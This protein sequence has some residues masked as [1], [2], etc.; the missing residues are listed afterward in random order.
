MALKYIPIVETK[1]KERWGFTVEWMSG[2]ADHYEPISY[3]FDT[4]EKFLEQLKFFRRIEAWYSKYHNLFCDVLNQDSKERVMKR[5]SRHYKDEE[6]IALSKILDNLF[7]SHASFSDMLEANN[8][9]PERDVTYS[10]NI[11]WPQ[12]P[13]KLVY[14]DKNGNKHMVEED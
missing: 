1:T 14:F 6:L 3:K 11:A 12:T 8:V 4:E 2:D 9:S 7:L 5:L 10:G 13:K